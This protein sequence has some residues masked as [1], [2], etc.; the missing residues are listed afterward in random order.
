MSRERPRPRVRLWII[1]R[2]FDVHVA[3][4]DPVEFLDYVQGLG[5]GEARL[6]DPRSAVEPDRIHY[7]C[8]VV[9]MTDRFAKP[10]RI[11]IRA[12]RPAVGEDLPPYVG[13]AFVND[14]GEIWSL[15]NAER[16]GRCAHARYTRR[17]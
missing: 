11:R 6:I 16:I 10:G 3:E 7:E 12:V 8:L 17:Q 14:H 5:R 9:P 15:D 1:H 2:V 4:I 13:P